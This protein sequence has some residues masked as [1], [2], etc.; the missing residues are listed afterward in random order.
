M[1]FCVDCYCRQCGQ[2]VEADPDFGILRHVHNNEFAIIARMEAG[3][4]GSESD[5]RAD[6]G[7]AVW[8]ES[9]L[10]NSFGRKFLHFLKRGNFRGDRF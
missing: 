5:G 1:C 8:N 10:G 4:I 6:G 3:C 9:G 7:A 2:R